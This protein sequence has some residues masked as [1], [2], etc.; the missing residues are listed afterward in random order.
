MQM[1]RIN[2]PLFYSFYCS[3]SQGSLCV[4]EWGAQTFYIKCKQAEMFAAMEAPQEVIFSC[5]LP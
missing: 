5:K 1:V 3:P 4:Y 2:G